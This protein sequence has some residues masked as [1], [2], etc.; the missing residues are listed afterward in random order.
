[1][2]GHEKTRGQVARVQGTRS[3]SCSG[4]VSCPRDLM[5]REAEAQ[6]AGHK[7][8]V[9]AS[10]LSWPLEQGVMACGKDPPQLP[11]R[12][13]GLKQRGQGSSGFSPPHPPLAVRLPG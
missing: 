6:E 9:A 12:H 5:T 4:Q 11:H 3:S 13:P 10:L 8:A 1:M 2:R 7:P